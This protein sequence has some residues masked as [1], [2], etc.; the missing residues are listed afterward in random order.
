[1][2]LPATNAAG[3][4]AF[5]LF[6]KSMTELLGLEISAAETDGLSKIISSPRVLTADQ[7]EA[8]I[9]DGKDLPYWSASSSGATTVSFKKA[10]L[11]LKVRPQI[12]PDG[13]VIMTVEVNKDSADPSLSTAYGIAIDTKNVKT[14]V[15]VDNGGTVVIGGIYIQDDEN[16][17]TKI[18][19]LGDIPLL[20]Y[21]FRKTDKTA[22]RN[23][24]LVF[25]TPK[26][27]SDTLS[28][29]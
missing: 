9:E 3:S 28:M 17:V 14:E 24:L 15:L 5:T 12:T 7:V 21:M 11:S 19:L 18:P 10:V 8:T 20:G 16:T 27:V 6:N 23:E 2:N 4:F 26:I 22:N 1:M 29:R 13:R 25:L